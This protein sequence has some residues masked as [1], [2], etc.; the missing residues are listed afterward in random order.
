MTLAADAS[1]GDDQA[2]VRVREEAAVPHHWRPIKPGA[3]GDTRK[4]EVDSIATQFGGDLVIVGPEEGTT[5]PERW[6]AAIEVSGV[7]DP[8]EMWKQIGTKGANKVIK[9]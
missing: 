2:S 6:Y 9:G 3:G 8:D 7:S 1:V 4:T 5:N